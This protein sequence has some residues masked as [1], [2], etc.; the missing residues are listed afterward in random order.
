MKRGLL[1]A[2]IIITLLLSSLPD[3]VFG[4]PPYAP[5]PNAAHKA[6]LDNT[7]FLPIVQTLPLPPIIPTTTKV[8]P[9]E[10]TQHLVAVSTDGITYTFDQDTSDL[11][12][13]QPGSVMVSGVAPNAPNGFL[14]K[15]VSL[16]KSSGQVNV[17]TTQAALTDAIQ[18]GSIRLNQTLT[19]SMITSA[20]GLPGVT[21]RPQ[22]A[23][24]SIF[25]LDLSNVVLY[26]GDGNPNTT[27]DQI[28]IHSGKIDI[29]PTVQFNIDM[30]DS[31]VTYLYFGAGAVEIATVPVDAQVNVSLHTPLK[32][33]IGKYPIGEF[34]TM[35]GPVPVIINALLEVNI[36]VSG[37]VSA[38]ISMDVTQTAT[39]T[40][41]AKYSGGQWGPAQSFTNNFSFTDPQ[42]VGSVAVKADIPVAQIDLFL[43]GIAGP[44]IGLG[45]Y[46]KVEQAMLPVVNGKLSGGLEA[47]V[48]INNNVDGI[49]PKL[50][51]YSL[52][53]TICELVLKPWGPNRVP[54]IPVILNPPDGILGTNTS[55]LLAW[56]GGDPYND[57]VTYTIYFQA[58]NSNPTTIISTDQNGTTFQLSNLAVNT[59]FYWKVIAKDDEARTTS[60]SVWSFTTGNPG[61]QLPTVDVKVNGSDRPVNLTRQEPFTVS[62]TSTNA[63]SCSGSGAMDGQSGLNSNYTERPKAP[64]NYTY[65]MSCTNG[66]GSASDSVF[67]SV[68]ATIAGGEM[69]NI[70]AGTFQ[71][72][73]DPAHNGLFPCPSDALPLHIVTLDTYQIDKYD[74]TNAQYAQCASVGACSPPSNNSSWTRASYYG[75]PIYNNYPVINVS[76]YDATN[77][78]SWAGKRL[79]S[80]AEW[81][82]AAKGSSGTRAYTWGDQEP[83]CTKA[84]YNST[85][86]D[87]GDTTAVGSYPAGASPYGVM[88]MAGNVWQWVNDWYS[89]NY[90]STS[91]ASNPLGP[92]SGIYKIM[93]GSGF[94]VTCD[95]SL[96]VSSRGITIYSPDYHHIDLG[97]RCAANP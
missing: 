57:P 23:D 91:P 21:L 50:I 87:V 14:R 33:N 53:W 31:Q 44:A 22:T 2:L 78:C 25:H 90:Y 72:G 89:S 70:P 94:G 92:T 35:I 93:R 66:S 3:P 56:E 29:N 27:N 95:P 13:L 43:Y 32:K 10:T 7:V 24:D 73:C 46:A 19:P 88:D 16:D 6:E 38:G 67:V 75:N 1:H 62:W 52:S 74:V 34:G 8:L 60:G 15:V 77:Y 12:Q 5:N 28:V 9:L 18:Q 30:K 11:D 84:N 20:H 97:F 55:V 69:V 82:K 61:S 96:L 51:N 17:Q 45:L 54:N 49:L 58:N 79:P 4:A 80:E 36:E 86:C 68:A 41:G 65:T 40:A 83:D 81:E 63:T 48:S 71:M 76:W 37:E 85:G 47:M 26:D 64:G 39:Y 59:H 42:V